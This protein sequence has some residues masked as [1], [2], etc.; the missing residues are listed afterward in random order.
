MLIYV[1][2]PRLTETFKHQGASAVSKVAASLVTLNSQ[3]KLFATEG[4]HGG[5]PRHNHLGASFTEI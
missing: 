1:G 5:T 3:S 2:D 4:T